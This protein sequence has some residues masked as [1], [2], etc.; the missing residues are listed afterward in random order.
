MLSRAAMSAA[1]RLASVS[2]VVLLL[3]ACGGR[4]AG[5]DEPRGDDAASDGG[6]ETS[7]AIAADVAPDAF[8]DG[9]TEDGS[10]DAFRVDDGVDT[11]PDAW[12]D[13]STFP[14]APFPDAT[15][16]VVGVD[17]VVD[18]GSDGGTPITAI[19]AEMT[20]AICTPAYQ[21]CC[22]AHGFSWDSLACS[23]VTG[24]WCDSSRDG[25]YA[26]KTV[27]D[28]SYADACIAAWASASS[29]CT[30]S[31]TDWIKNQA[32]CSQM[33]NGKT[34]PGGACTRSSDCH[35]DGGYTAWCDDS[36]KR[37]REYA[38][39]A[40][41][42]SCIDFG[43]AP[44]ICDKGLVCDYSS[45]SGAVCRDATPVGGSCFGLDDTSCGLGYT[46]SAG[47]CAAGLAAGASCS[48]DLQCASWSCSGGHC[49]DP[50]VVVANKSFCSGG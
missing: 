21:M 11:M 10:G 12:T 28:P 25:V 40:K 42:A 13:D 3:A 41:G 44:R 19:C 8:E 5:F 2:V 33:F 47:K 37:C 29:A 4:V 27:Y 35:A 26:G 18:V 48:Y 7:D 14:D 9:S 6:D 15:S 39:V 36:S 50:N 43:V 45:G 38:I 31:L 30:M 23:D 34:A 1:A 46:C 24:I 32:P 49:T 20:S 22:T 16:D 17:V